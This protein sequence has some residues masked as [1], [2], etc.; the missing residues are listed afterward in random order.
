MNSDVLNV[1]IG[2]VFVWF[3]LSVVLSAVNEGLAL[4]THVRAKHLWLGIGRLVDPN[5]SPLPRRFLDAAFRAPCGAVATYAGLG[6][7]GHGHG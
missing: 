2:V 3:L 5:N 4:V 6:G 1:A 7:T